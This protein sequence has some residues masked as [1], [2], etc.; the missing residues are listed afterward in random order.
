[1]TEIRKKPLF[2]I[3]IKDD[4]LVINN[5]DYRKDNGVFEIESI[6]NVQLI[7]ICLF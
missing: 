7:E 6:E 2:E 5:T 1:M 3:Y 4:Y